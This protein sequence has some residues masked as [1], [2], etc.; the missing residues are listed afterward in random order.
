[1]SRMQRL[2]LITS[3]AFSLG[4]FHGP[5]IRDLVGAGVEVY[6]LAPDYDPA[7][8]MVVRALGAVPVDFSLA[9][10][11]MNPLHDGLDTLRLAR[12]LRRLRVDISFGYFIKPVIYGT[13]AAWLARVPR[14][15]ALI[16]GLGYVFT[17]SGRADSW[18]RRVLRHAVSSLYGV[19][20]RAGQAGAVL[21]DDLAEFV[22]RGIVPA[23][24]SIKL[25][26]LASTS[27]NGH[28]LRW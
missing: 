25:G 16:K 22:S 5:Q 7:Q 10:T 11:G 8:R 17:G 15:L 12:L 1:M 27:P 14:R 18:R 4:N 9:C 26:V 19:A 21:N 28:W 24:K 13:L 3:Q 23:A 2:A 6:A 20:L